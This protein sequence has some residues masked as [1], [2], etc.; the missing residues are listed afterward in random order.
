M[1]LNRAAGLIE[2]FFLFFAETHLVQDTFFLFI[3]DFPRKFCYGVVMV[4][5]VYLINNFN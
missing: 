3:V 1:T 4:Y 2:V 5:S